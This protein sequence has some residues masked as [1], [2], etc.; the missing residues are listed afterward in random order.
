MKRLLLTLAVSISTAAGLLAVAPTALAATPVG[1]LDQSFTIDNGSAYGVSGYRSVAQTF[2]AGVSG[3]LSSVSVSLN[4]GPSGNTDITVELAALDGPG[5]S[6]GSVLASDTTLPTNIAN[7]ACPWP[8]ACDMVVNFT[9][10][11][12]VTSG[13]SYAI[14]LRTTGNTYGWHGDNGVVSPQSWISD[15][16]GPWSG[17]GFTLD[18][19]TYVTPLAPTSKNQCKDGGWQNL[20]DN[21]GT[22]FK[23]QG[24]CVSYVA[25][26]GK[27][28]ADG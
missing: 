13:Q 15:G 12:S 17:P 27:N 22:P 10:P 7:G 8:A 24:D 18:F 5:G 26:G 21:N 23:N 14:V 9:N 28:K 6:P 4:G 2:T 20:T 16:G 25:T 19:A 3:K 11:A 1:T